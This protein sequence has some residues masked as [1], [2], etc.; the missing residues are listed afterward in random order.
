MR[1]KIVTVTTG[2]RADYGILRPLLKKISLSKKLQLILIVT[3]SHLSKNHGNTIQEIIKDGFKINTKINIVPKKDDSFHIS[4][5]I[6]KGIIEFSKCFKKLKPDFNIVF[7]D[8]YEMLSSTVAAYNQNIPNVHIHGGDKSG[9]LDEY[10]R[11]A[12]TKMSNIHFAAT[13]KSATRIKKM[14]ENPKYIIQSGSLSIDEIIK[15]K[16]SSLE[17]LN[18][19]YNL[20]LTGN[21]IIVLQ[22]PDTTEPHKSKEQILATLKAVIK[23]KH[24]AVIIGPN[25]DT[26]NDSINKIIK[27]YL[28]NNSIKF[29]KSLPREDYLGLLNNCKLLI[30]NSSSGIIEST[31][32]KIPVINIGNRQKG[33]ERGPNVIDV[34]KFSQTLI[35]VAIKKALSV[36]KST[37]KIKHVYGNGLSAVKITKYLEKINI[38]QSLLRKEIAY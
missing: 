35:S 31:L 10:T 19:K 25:M 15:N 1:K 22:H 20:N 3:G 16:I 24:N 30:G 7:G 18:L 5:S 34:E 33:R 23:T 6:G 14:G 37:L 32:F 29:F 26:G 12:I 4:M 21:E 17:E 27:K 9:G 28:K 13:Q 38:E 36:N 8:R 2:T 11:H